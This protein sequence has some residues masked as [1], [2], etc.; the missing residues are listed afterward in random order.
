MIGMPRIDPV[1]PRNSSRID[2]NVMLQKQAAKH[3]K[4]RLRLQSQYLVAPS[5][6]LENK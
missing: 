3:T 5:L 6:S 4:K 2:S 1:R